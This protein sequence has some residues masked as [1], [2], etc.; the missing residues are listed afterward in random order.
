MWWGEVSHSRLRHRAFTKAPLVLRHKYHSSPLLY[1]LSSHLF[2]SPLTSRAHPTLQIHVRMLFLPSIPPSLHI[3]Q[4]MYLCFVLFCFCFCF[5]FIFCLILILLDLWKFMLTTRCT[6][7]RNTWR[8]QHYDYDR[9]AWV[10]P[11]HWEVTSIFFEQRWLKAEAPTFVPAT[12]VSLFYIKNTPLHIL[13]ISLSFCFSENLWEWWELWRTTLLAAH[14]W[15]VSSF[16]PFF[17]LS[18]SLLS[19]LLPST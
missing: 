11:S 18:P 17:T 8:H 4:R 5:C 14:Q 10:S 15:E 9:Q 6:T 12:Q 2:V 7:Q 13:I 16:I 3:L 1:V 19:L